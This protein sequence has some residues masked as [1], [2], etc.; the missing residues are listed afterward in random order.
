[1]KTSNKY[2]NP[3]VHNQITAP[4]SRCA[5]PGAHAVVRRSATSAIGDAS[6]V[7]GTRNVAVAAQLRS[8][9]AS[10]VT[11][12]CWPPRECCCVH[13]H[14]FRVPRRVFDGQRCVL[15]AIRV[16]FVCHWRRQLVAE[17]QMRRN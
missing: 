5:H 15:G 13:R 3:V 7:R 2:E 14:T 17:A 1:M 6:V 9:A 11:V 12:L 10:R 4:A 8:R 16:R